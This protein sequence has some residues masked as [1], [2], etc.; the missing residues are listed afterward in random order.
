MSSRL[1]VTGIL[2]RSDRVDTVARGSRRRG[3][4]KHLASCGRRHVFVLHV[5]FSSGLQL[6]ARL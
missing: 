5:L 6:T 1:N 2:I 3:A 4:G